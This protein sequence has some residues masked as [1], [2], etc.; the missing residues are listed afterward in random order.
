MTAMHDWRTKV[1]EDFCEEND[2]EVLVSDEWKTMQKKMVMRKGT[3]TA[4]RYVDYSSLPTLLP[5]A[6]LNEMLIEIA[7]KDGDGE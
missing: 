3:T 4:T 7:K 1:V 6:L 5:S 2:V